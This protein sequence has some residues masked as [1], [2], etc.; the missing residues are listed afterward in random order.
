MKFL[1]IV[2][3]NLCVLFL[4]VLVLELGA[5]LVATTAPSYQVLFL[6]PD[7]KLGWKHAP[8]LSFTWTGHYWYAADFSV[9]VR[10]NRRGFRDVTTNFDKP[11]GVTRVALLG[12][13][14]LEALQVP[15]EHTADF[16][17]EKK[18]NASQP[19]TPEQRRRWEVLNF[20]V[21]NYGVGQYLLAWQ[22]YARWYSPD[23]VAVF[24]S[25][26]H[27]KRTVRKYTAGAFSSSDGAHLWVRPIFQLTE[28]DSLVM[29]PARDYQAF[30]DAQNK[31]I[32][33]EFD[34]SRIRKRRQIITLFYAEE[35]WNRF[36]NIADELYRKHVRKLPARDPDEIEGADT[37]MDEAEVLEINLRI[38]KALGEDVRHRNAKLVLL[39]ASQYFGDDPSISAALKR[40]SEQNNFGYVP[41]YSNLM[42]ARLKGVVIRWPHDG[43][44]NKTGNEIVATALY[45]WISDVSTALPPAK[46]AYGRTIRR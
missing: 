43:H 32:K 20:G 17:L 38:I 10:S 15:M 39:D 34:G 5:Q 11:A 9:P 41:I 46:P 35:L 16:L 6:Q 8:N 2:A 14:F 45:D 19:F 33:E 29:I 30:V 36:R 13:S 44:F 27:M 4:L 40:L 7:R 22:E 24:V 18:L 31:V 26:F 42:A 12:N 21:S 25:F 1:R 28:D 3:G 37:E 23:Y